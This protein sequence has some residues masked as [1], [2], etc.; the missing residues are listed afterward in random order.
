MS[1]GRSANAS[2]AVRRAR[3]TGASFLVHSHLHYAAIVTGTSGTVGTRAIGTAASGGM[4]AS[5]VAGDASASGGMLLVSS[6]G[7]RGRRHGRHR[8]GTEGHGDIRSSFHG[9]GSGRC[10]AG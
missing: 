4:D 9:L 8:A 5:S 7:E 1:R 10:V 3:S 6:L 2:L